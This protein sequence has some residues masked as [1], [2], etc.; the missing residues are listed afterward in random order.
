MDVANK[1]VDYLIDYF[2]DKTG[3]KLEDN[4]QADAWKHLLKSKSNNLTKN[5]A[6]RGQMLIKPSNGQPCA[7]LSNEQ[8]N[9]GSITVPAITCD[10]KNAT[11]TP[12]KNHIL[13]NETSTLR[14]GINH[15]ANNN[16][17]N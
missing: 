1:T 16:N 15:P 8:V 14:N 2:S 4:P 11:E 10:A 9:V 7:L 5:D 13:F 3:M 17:R 6:F 12:P